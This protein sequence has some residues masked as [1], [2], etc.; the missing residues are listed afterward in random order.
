MGRILFPG[1]NPKLLNGLCA[2]AK[3][4]F[5]CHVRGPSR[6]LDSSFG[7]LLTDSPVSSLNEK[8]EFQDETVS[9]RIST[10][11]V[12][13]SVIVVNVF[14]AAGYNSLSLSFFFSI[15]G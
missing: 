8:D 12:A 9:L 10:L 4:D 14:V 1:R 2:T 5:L 15:F 7:H 6:H 11:L 3:I 13:P